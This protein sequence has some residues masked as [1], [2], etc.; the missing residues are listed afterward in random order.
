MHTH[1]STHTH[2]QTF[3]NPLM[4][5]ACVSNLIPMPNAYTHS[6]AHVLSALGAGKLQTIISDCGDTKL[7]IHRYTFKYTLSHAHT[8]THART[9]IGY[10]SP[11][12]DNWRVIKDVINL[13]LV[14]NSQLYGG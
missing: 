9:H 5:T 2:T 14:N 11:H 10:L 13:Y 4:W 8:H 3:L 12:I 7:D 1:T 6:I